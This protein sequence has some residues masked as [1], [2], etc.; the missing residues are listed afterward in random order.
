MHAYIFCLNAVQWNISQRFVIIY[1]FGHSIER[2]MCLLARFISLS[3][4]RNHRKFRSFYFINWTLFLGMVWCASV[5][6][7]STSIIV[8]RLFIIDS[9]N[10]TRFRMRFSSLLQKIFNITRYCY[11]YIS[12]LGL[13]WLFVDPMNPVIIYTPRRTFWCLQNENWNEN[14]HAKFNE[15][16]GRISIF[17]TRYDRPT[18]FFTQQ[19]VW[20]ATINHCIDSD[21]TLLIGN[22]FDSDQIQINF[23]LFSLSIDWRKRKTHHNNTQKKQLRVKKPLV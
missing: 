22:E 8:H 5:I 17:P 9:V 2:K 23:T 10:V 4:K 16:N 6:F 7:L 21:T 3:L 15:L 11:I 18:Q 14:Q 13:P 20:M 12:I 1:V 19:F